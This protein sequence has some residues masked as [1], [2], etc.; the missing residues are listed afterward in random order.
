M[1]LQTYTSRMNGV[2]RWPQLDK[3]WQKLDTNEGW[4]LY[5]IG[6]DVPTKPLSSG[7]LQQAIER[8]DTFLHLEHEAEYCGVVY[9]DNLNAPGVLKIYHPK[10]MG[11]SCGSSG[12]TVLPKWTLSKYPPID[13]VEWALEKDQKPAW[14]KHMLRPRG[15]NT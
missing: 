15:V 2:L 11:A 8:I 12:S 4:Y 5:E 7:A 10:K 6:N 14:W 3:L 1:F 13:L 9:T